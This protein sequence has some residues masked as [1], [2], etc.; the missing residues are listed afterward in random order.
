MKRF[1]VA[2]LVVLLL[3]FPGCCA[4]VNAV[5]PDTNVSIESYV[6]ALTRIKE[7]V[8]VMRGDHEAALKRA[9]PPYVPAL[10]EAELGVY[11]STIL[12]CDDALTGSE[13]KAPAEGGGE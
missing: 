13:G 7:K 3:L 5:H 1:G 9:Q 4:S 11:D 8:A 2:V 6:N 12:L 10:M